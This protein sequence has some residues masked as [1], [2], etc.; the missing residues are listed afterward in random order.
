[1]TTYI[2]RQLF[3]AVL[4]FIALTAVTVLSTGSAS[5]ATPGEPAP[6]FSH[7]TEQ[8]TVTNPDG[9]LD[10]ALP[11]TDSLSAFYDAQCVAEVDGPHPADATAGGDATPALGSDTPA[12]PPGA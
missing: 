2:S 3:I 9:V 4:A 6:D 10:P 11:P 8:C 5:A 1:M 12:N 7:P